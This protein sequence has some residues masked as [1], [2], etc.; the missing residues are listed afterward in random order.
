MM[1]ES[2]VKV[3][4]S[5]AHS[6]LPMIKDHQQL[7]HGENITRLDQIVTPTEIIANPPQNTDFYELNTR[8]IKSN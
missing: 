7:R 2:D 8:E 4:S 1:P 5:S 6:K 3:V